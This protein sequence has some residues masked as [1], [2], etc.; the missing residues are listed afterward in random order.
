MQM[1]TVTNSFGLNF[2]RLQK[3]SKSKGEESTD[4]LRSSLSTVIQILEEVRKTAAKEA[5]GLNLCM[6]QTT[7][8]TTSLGRRRSSPT[9]VLKS[10][11]AALDS[12]VRP[13]QLQDVVTSVDEVANW[14]LGLVQ[15]MGNELQEKKAELRNRTA[16]LSGLQQSMHQSLT[17]MGQPKI[18]FCE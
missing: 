11:P 2:E 15:K 4:S 8:A 18:S 10:V 9:Q 17:N 14:V 7:S 13:G 1:A 5:A 16:E 3:E 6:E 12:D